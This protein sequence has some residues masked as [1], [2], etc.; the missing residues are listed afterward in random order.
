MGALPISDHLSDLLQARTIFED[1]MTSSTL[2]GKNTDSLVSQQDSGLQ[3]V[4]C[5]MLALAL[6]YSLAVLCVGLFQPL[7][8]QYFSRQTQTALTAYWLAQGG[9][10]FAYETPTA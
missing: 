2:D 5:A 7:L 8:D 1:A 9:P 10:I 4:L 3:R 6:V